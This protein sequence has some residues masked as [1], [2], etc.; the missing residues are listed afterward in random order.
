[1]RTPLYDEHRALG[2]RMVDFAGW[3]MPV[4]YEG[5]LSE[6]ARTRT[7]CTVFDTCHMGEFELSGPTAEADLERLLT[8]RVGTLA[9][10]QCRYGYLL[11]DDGGVLDDL[12][13]YRF[14]PDRFWLIVNA[15]TRASDFEWIRAHV[16]PG[17]RLQD[18]S[19]ELGKLDVQGPRSWWVLGEALG[20]PVPPLTYFRLAETEWEGHTLVISRTGYTGE[21]GYE[22]YGPAEI[23]LALWRR[24]VAAGA[25]PAGLGARDTL[26]LEMG[27]PLYGHELS[28]ERTPVA[29][30]R[31][32]F[33][34][35]GKEFIGGAAVRRDL[36]RG[37]ARYLAGL[38][39]EG[40]RAAR[41]GAVALW[42]GRAVGEVTSG[43][44]APSLGVAVAL[45]YLDA[46]LAREGVRLE[47]EVG[48]ARLTATVVS[49]PFWT[50]GTARASQPPGAI[51]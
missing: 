25:T 4:Q 16:S 49:L 44:Y 18:R 46:E 50:A 37:C 14:G 1:M 29:A 26:R 12:T 13:C 22:V 40:R 32:A 9:V 34:D 20:R 48:R 28:V 31:G 30:A 6:H 11:R 45:A 24:L 39:L 19:D 7:A 10:G 36:E 38:R 8:M 17:T 21:W 2:A 27:Y 33:V 51:A 35:I 15:G 42:D 47:L 41:G 23:A 5:I 3:E 43:A